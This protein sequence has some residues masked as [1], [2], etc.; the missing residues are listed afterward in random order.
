M[1]RMYAVMLW[2]ALAVALG[3][4]TGLAIE[5]AI[6]GWGLKPHEYEPPAGHVQHETMMDYRR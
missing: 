4:M 2:A 5:G 3:I 6:S 1:G